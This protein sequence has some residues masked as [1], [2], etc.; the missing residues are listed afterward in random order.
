MR[1]N[2]MKRAEVGNWPFV[3]LFV[4]QEPTFTG[5]ESVAFMQWSRSYTGSEMDIR[6]TGLGCSFI[7]FTG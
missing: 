2:K 6:Y 4:P 5:T 7:Y 3:E 1:G